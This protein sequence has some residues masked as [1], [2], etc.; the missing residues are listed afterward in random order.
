[1]AVAGDRQRLAL[2]RACHASDASASMLQMPLPGPQGSRLKAAN[3]ASAPKWAAGH[4]ATRP[5]RHWPMDMTVAISTVQ[6]GFGARGQMPALKMMLLNEQ[7]AP[8]GLSLPSD[9]LSTRRCPLLVPAMAA[10]FLRLQTLL[11]RRFDLLQA[12]S[13]TTRHPLPPA[14]SPPACAAQFSSK[15]ETKY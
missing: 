13:H 9:C 14:L 6:L 2:V 7:T 8:L 5:T 4:C 12:Y 1:L 3:H 11:L 15:Y 10:S